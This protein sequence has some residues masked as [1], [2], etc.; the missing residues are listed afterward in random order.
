MGYVEIINLVISFF[1]LLVAATYIGYYFI[2]LA[3]IFSKQKIFPKCDEK[4][5]Y[6]VIICARNEEIVIG[7]LIKS[8]YKCLYPQN[9][10]TVFVMA[11]NC[12]DNTAEVARTNGAIVYEYNNADEKTKGYALKHMFEV[13]SRD[14]GIDSF[15]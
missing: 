7:N 6:G 11:H 5:K 3:G 9:K 8:V 4:L 15:D 12:T 1:V 14:Y 13:I 2:L 10:L